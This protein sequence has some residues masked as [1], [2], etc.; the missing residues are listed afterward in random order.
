MQNLFIC[1]KS[2]NDSLKKQFI[3][4]KNTV[5]VKAIEVTV[6]GIA[7]TKILFS[8]IHIVFYSESGPYMRCK[9]FLWL[10]KL[11]YKCK[12][13]L[14]HILPSNSASIDISVFF[15]GNI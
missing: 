8:I 10:G 4:N 12:T 6:I 2:V 13:N 11:L 7:Y 1:M 14:K 5:T 3:S 15:H 9:Y